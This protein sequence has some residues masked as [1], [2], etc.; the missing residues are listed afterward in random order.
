[1]MVRPI[2]KAQVVSSAMQPLASRPRWRSS[3]S[4]TAARARKSVSTDTRARS[5][6]VRARSMMRASRPATAPIIPDT[7]VSRNTGATASW[8]PWVTA[9]GSRGKA[10]A[11]Y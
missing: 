2:R 9:P 4:S 8:M 7:A 10:M 11:D 6:T 5:S 1:M 3:R